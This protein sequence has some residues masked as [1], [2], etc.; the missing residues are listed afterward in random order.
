MYF[1][2]YCWIIEHN[3][4]NNKYKYSKFL[5]NGPNRYL[6][7]VKKF[8]NDSFIIFKVIK[9]SSGRGQKKPPPVLIGLSLKITWKL[10]FKAKLTIL[11]IFACLKFLHFFL[12]RQSLAH[13]VMFVHICSYLFWELFCNKVTFSP[14]V[15]IR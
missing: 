4:I 11:T 14:F 2:T 12:M 8:Q 7:I 3:Y 15:A 6:L 9:K 10:D 13:E 1:H 5:L